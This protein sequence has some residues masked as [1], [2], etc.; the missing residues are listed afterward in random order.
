MNYQ[1]ALQILQIPES[2]ATEQ[3]VQSAFR[4]AVKRHHPDTGGR[5]RDF[6]QVID[7]RNTALSVL[8]NVRLPRIELTL[9]QTVDGMSRCRL[10]KTCPSCHGIAKTATCQACNGYGVRCRSCRGRGE[11]IVPCTTC[12]NFG[13]VLSEIT[14]PERDL[15]KRVV[16]VDG[17]SYQAVLV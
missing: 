2:R 14:L 1:E 5:S 15:E 13:Y 17:V 16:K 8:S 10:R 4:A 7:A 6:Q 11:K 3:E 9:V 12:R